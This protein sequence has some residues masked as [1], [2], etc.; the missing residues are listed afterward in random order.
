M[1]K[2]TKNFYFL[3]Y[4]CLFYRMKKIFLSVFFL[5]AFSTA[6]SQTAGKYK[7]KYE[8]IYGKVFKHTKHLANIVK[9]SSSGSEIAVEWQTAGEELWHQDYNFPSVGVGVNFL[10]LGNPPILGYSI[11]AYPYLNTPIIKNKYFA[12]NVKMGLGLSYVTRTFNDTKIYDGAGN[13]LFDESNAA[14]GSHLNVFISSGLN[15]EIPLMPNLSLTADYLWNHISNGSIIVPNSGLNM[16]NSYIGF[17]YFAHSYT[18]Q[19]SEKKQSS[20]LRKEILTEVTISGG[21]RQRHYTDNK[22]LPIA[23]IAVGVYKPFSNIYRMGIGLDAFYDGI[24]TNRLNAN[25]HR[26]YIASDSFK[27]KVRIGLSWQHELLLG[28][29]VGG[30]HTGIYLYNPIKNLEPYNDAK[31]R[32]LN[33]GLI[34]PY[35]IEEEDGWFYTRF[36]IKYFVSKRFFISTGLKTHLQK[37]EFIEWGVGFRL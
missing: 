35:N 11:S 19:Q 3:N 4:P 30:I 36:L 10:D 33:K 15:L 18:Y 20:P 24:F 12:F 8:F 9:G 26:T 22:S 2:V 32:N 34:Y 13:I 28:K 37:A 14:I 23:S 29:F 1:S 21:T 27:N 25:Y 17:K 7:V 6:H 31:N 5:I 16:L